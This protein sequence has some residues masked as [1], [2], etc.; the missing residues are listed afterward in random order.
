MLNLWDKENLFLLFCSAECIM[1]DAKARWSREVTLRSFIIST[2]F[3]SETKIR[4]SKTCVF[5]DLEI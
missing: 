2:K 5:K 1:G 4:Q 3:A